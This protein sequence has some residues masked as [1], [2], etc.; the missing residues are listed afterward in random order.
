MKHEI[1]LSVFLIILVGSVSAF[2]ISTETVESTAMPDNP[3][4]IRISV[5]NDGSSNNSYRLSVRDYHRSNWYNHDKTVDVAPGET[6]YFNLSI[7]PGTDAIQ[8]RYSADFVVREILSDEVQR[9]SFTYKVLRDTSLNLESF[10]VRPEKLKPGEEVNVSIEVRNV[11]S[12]TVKDPNIEL[13]FGEEVIRPEIGAILPG[14]T[15]ELQ[16]SFKI[17]RFRD[18]G[19]KEIGLSIEDRNYTENFEVVELENLT[20]NSS[21]VNRV[22]WIR[23]SYSFQNEGNTERNFTFERERPS[24][25][26]PLVNAEGAEAVQENS[27][28]VYSWKIELE[29]GEEETVNLETNYWLPAGALGLLVVALVA[30]KRIT[31]SISVFKSIENRGDEIVVTLEVENSSSKTYDDVILEDYIPNI[32]SVTSNFEMASPELKDTGEGTKLRWWIN[33]LEPG[34]Q[35]IFK[36]TLRPKVEVED[37]VTL[38]PAELKDGET[39][40][41]TTAKEDIEFKN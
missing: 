29:P 16:N 20:Q 27:S 2:Q 14:G 32:A 37:G 21:T 35:R 1:L 22:L 13:M 19:L 36:Y 41:D 24:Y 10:N 7:R 38:D 6:G 17:D 5:S 9:G 40:L 33:D 30:L 39:T 3:G 4:E 12:T 34:D 31:S 23:N 8:N 28:T 18:P 15:R 26:N 25:L 11:A